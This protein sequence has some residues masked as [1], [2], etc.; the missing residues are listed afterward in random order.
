[1]VEVASA[2]N[3]PVCRIMDYG[4]YKYET[5][6]RAKE[7]RRKSTSVSVKE[8]R[9]K[10]RIGQGDFDTKTRK[11]VQ[12]LDEGHKVKVLLTFRGREMHHP[13]LGQKILDRVVAAVGEVGKVE[14]MP[15]QEG[16]NMTMILGPQRQSGKKKKP[17]SDD[18]AAAPEVAEAPEE[19]SAADQEG[20][21]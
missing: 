21:T 13:E 10:P 18:G 14:S 11:V 15:R 16:R 17:A 9:Y 20:A 8:M 19:T 3:P 4:K 12:F 6:Q 7:S 1:L 2:A 5:A